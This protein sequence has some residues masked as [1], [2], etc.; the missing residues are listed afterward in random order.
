M[1]FRNCDVSSSA[2]M[3]RLDLLYRLENMEVYHWVISVDILSRVALKCN[4]RNNTKVTIGIYDGPGSLSPL[5]IED[6][7]Y[8]NVNCSTFK[9]YTL[10]ESQYIY[11]REFNVQFTSQS[12]NDIIELFVSHESGLNYHISSIL[13]LPFTC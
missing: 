10:L 9:C 12:N 3:Q 2:F 13:N 11:L 7:A 4:V 5:L 1:P 6:N 8:I